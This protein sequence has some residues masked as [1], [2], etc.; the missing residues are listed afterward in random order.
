MTAAAQIALY[1]GEDWSQQLS[2]FT[3]LAQTVPQLF[4]QPYMDLVNSRGRI[5]TFS[6]DG[7]REGLATITGP[8]VLVLSM[9]WAQTSLLPPGTYPLDIFANVAGKRKAITKIGT[10]ELVVTASVTTDSNLSMALAQ[11]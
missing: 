4:T 11:A 7:D 5:A 3:D 8:G 6:A 1:Q 10:I 2:F 9:P